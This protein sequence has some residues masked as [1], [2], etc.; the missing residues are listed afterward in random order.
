MPRRERPCL[1]HSEDQRY[2]DDKRDKI[3][4]KDIWN[5]ITDGDRGRDVHYCTPPAQIRTCGLPAYGSHLGCLTA[6]RWLGQGWRIVGLGSQ[7]SAIC[8]MRSQTRAPAWLRRRTVLPPPPMPPC[9]NAPS[10][11]PLAPPPSS[12]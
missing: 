11:R 4:W 8:S 5:E 10:A 6:K 2:L 9:P 3:K 7:S 12:Y 1:Q